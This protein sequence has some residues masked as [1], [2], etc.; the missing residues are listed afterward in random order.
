MYILT[1]STVLQLALGI[2]AFV[3]Y[4][5]TPS[6]PIVRNRFVVNAVSCSQIFLA[7]CCIKLLER[8]YVS[9]SNLIVL[10]HCELSW[11]QRR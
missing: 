3:W 5:I 4:G 10:N 7:I 8:A 6:S 1:V 9:P 11:H 2:W